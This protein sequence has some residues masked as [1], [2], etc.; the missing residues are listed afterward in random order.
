MPMRHTAV[1]ANPAAIL[2]LAAVYVLAGTLGLQLAF[3]HPSVTAVWPP[4]GMA[5]AAGLVLGYRIWPGVLL[6]AFL[7]NLIAAGSVTT[8]L[9]IACG[10]TLE[11]LL[12]TYLV[13]RYAHGRGAFEH[14]HDIWRFVLLAGMVSTAVSA[15]VGVTMLVLGG[16]ALW[17][18]YGSL[19]GTWW[20]GDAMG[21]LIVTPLV[22]S[23]S[24]NRRWHWTRRQTVEAVLVLL[25][26][27][28]VG[29]FVFT[30]LLPAGLQHQPLEFLCIPLLIW[31]AFRF[32]PRE[33]TTATVILA[34][35]A[36][37]GTLSGFGPFARSTP[38]T[39][40][41]LLQAFLGV[42]TVTIMVLA[43]AVSERQQAEERLK[44]SLREKE[45]LLKEI[46]HRVKNNLQVISSLLNLQA[47]SIKDPQVL[48]L[49]EDCQ[50]RINAMALIHQSLYRADNLARIDFGA[51]LR[52]LAADLLRACAG[53]SARITL[54]TAA[55]DLMLSLDTAIPC[56]LL[57][58]ELLTNSLKHAFPN[59]QPGKIQVDLRREPDGQIVL[60]VC[61]TGVGLPA[62]V[63]LQTTDSFGLQLVRILSRQLQA[64]IDLE[65]H[66]GTTITIAFAE[67]TYTTRG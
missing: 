10:N 18:A 37:W 46:H 66:P 62:G 64:I 63:D 55:D 25:A 36:I 32:G 3:L 48:A 34:G 54:T 38:H 40:F 56:G 41:L 57:V 8:S 27:G 59:E 19:W 7:V 26:V 13:N 31:T 2:L 23:W 43:A 9:G 65:R 16:F 6:G 5:L 61:D 12:G 29:L 24:N 22:L 11:A 14:V 20:L 52:T 28:L 45:V 42:V 60:R 1:V 39:S 21:A 50:Y 15:T 49:F 51:Y 47:D 35:M 44:V 30:G 33:A 53:D 4:T 67:P 17:A 58:N